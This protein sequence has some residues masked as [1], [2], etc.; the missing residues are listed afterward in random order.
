M[1]HTPGPWQSIR[2]GMGQSIIGGDGKSVASTGNSKR[3]PAENAAN[4]QLI[5]KAPVLLAEVENLTAER[6][7]LRDALI[8]V[9]RELVGAAETGNVPDL[10]DWMIR[11]VDL[12]EATGTAPSEVQP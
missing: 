1:K 4:A 3:Y 11:S 6:N 7:K 5:A 10:S 8:E 9:L 2:R 12:L